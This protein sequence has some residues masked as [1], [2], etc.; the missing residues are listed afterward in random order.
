MKL[1]FFRPKESRL[2]KA[3]VWTVEIFYPICP[4]VAE[5][6]AFDS[7]DA[8]RETLQTSLR[9][10]GLV[11]PNCFEI[12]WGVFFEEPGHFRVHRKKPC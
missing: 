7:L 1:P 8:L 4:A 3:P 2:K 11:E 12:I 6:P 9:K 5:V 10:H